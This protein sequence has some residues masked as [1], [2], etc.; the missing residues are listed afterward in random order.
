MKVDIKSRLQQIRFNTTTAN[1]MLRY[2]G[3]RGLVPCCAGK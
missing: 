2:D 1:V 3:R